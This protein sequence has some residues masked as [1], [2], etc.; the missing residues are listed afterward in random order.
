VGGV[1]DQQDARG[2][3]AAQAV[4]HDGEHVDVVP[5]LESVGPSGQ[6]GCQPGDVVHQLLQAGGV[7][8]VVAALGDDVGDLEVV[9]P[10]DHHEP[11]ARTDDEGQPVGVGSL[12]RQPEPQHVHRRAEG[13]GALPEEPADVGVAPIARDGEVRPNLDA[14][15]GTFGGDADNAAAA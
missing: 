5:R 15:V 8:R 6:R 10:V 2:V 12:P 7:H 14:P 9:A 1:A 4:D 13:A 11:H 3:P